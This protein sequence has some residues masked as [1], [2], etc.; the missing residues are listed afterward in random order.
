MQELSEGISLDTMDR[1][2]RRKLLYRQLCQERQRIRRELRHNPPQ[3]S[4]TFTGDANERHRDRDGEEHGAGL[5][6]RLSS[7]RGETPRGREHPPAEPHDGTRSHHRR[8]RRDAGEPMPE[9]DRQ[10]L[11]VSDRFYQ[12]TQD[13]PTSRCARLLPAA[14]PLSPTR[15][16]SISFSNYFRTPIGATAPD[17][18]PAVGRQP[19]PVPAPP[20][21]SAGLSSSQN[22][23]LPHHLSSTPETALNSARSRTSPS[24]TPALP[25]IPDG[26]GAVLGV[27]VR[28]PSDRPTAPPT[29]SQGP[30]RPRA[31][32]QGA[33]PAPVL[34]ATTVVPRQPAPGGAAPGG[35]GEVVRQYRVFGQSRIPVDDGTSSHSHSR[36]RSRTASMQR[37]SRGV[38]PPGAAGRPQFPFNP[39]GRASR[40]YGPTEEKESTPS[41]QQN[42]RSRTRSPQNR[43][44]SPQ[45]RQ[46]RGQRGSSPPRGPPSPVATERPPGDEGR[47]A[48][49]TFSPPL[50]ERPQQQQQQQQQPHTNAGSYILPTPRGAPPAQA[51]RRYRAGSSGSLTSLPYAVAEGT[52]ALV[53]GGAVMPP[54]STPLATGRSHSLLDLHR[55]SFSIA[56]GAEYLASPIPSGRSRWAGAGGLSGRRHGS[57]FSISVASCQSYGSLNNSSR[58][59][60]GHFHYAPAGSAGASAASFGTPL[61]SPL[62]TARRLRQRNCSASLSTAVI[63]SAVAPA[64]VVHQEPSRPSNTTNSASG[65]R[66]Q[67]QVGS[68]GSDSNNP[69]NASDKSP[70]V[71]HTP[72]SKRCVAQCGEP[73][74]SGGGDGGAKPSVGLTTPSARYAGHRTAAGP[75]PEEASNSNSNSLLLHVEHPQQVEL[76]A[77]SPVGR[78]ALQ[79]QR[80]DSANNNSSE[81]SAKMIVGGG[82]THAY[83]SGRGEGGAQAA[84]QRKPPKLM[85]EMM[86]HGQTPSANCSETSSPAAI[87]VPSLLRRQS[88][89]DTLRYAA[90]TQSFALKLSDEGDQGERHDGGVLQVQDGSPAVAALEEAGRRPRRRGGRA[91]ATRHRRDDANASSSSAASASPLKRESTE[92]DV[93]EGVKR[94]TENNNEKKEEEGRTSTPNPRRKPGRESASPPPGRRGKRKKKKDK[95]SEQMQAMKAF[96][97]I[98]GLPGAS[99]DANTN[100]IEQPCDSS[101]PAPSPPPFYFQLPVSNNEQYIA[102]LIIETE[103]SPTDAFS[104]HIP[105]GCWLLI[106]V[107]LTEEEKIMRRTDTHQY[108]ESTESY[109]YEVGPFTFVL[110]K[111]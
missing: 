35:T 51:T 101:L 90:R 73:P 14:E 55:A 48:N 1:N 31:A 2:V 91:S 110:E 94:T 108:R 34:T 11:L 45:Q 61:P 68:Q 64:V 100:A 44:Q 97:K 80:V 19:S 66:A 72:L 30:I 41:G 93:D 83:F 12:I 107:F 67:Q 39:R 49:P 21:G 63:D 111:R 81:L 74:A 26:A 79:Q 7:S 69:N 23:S 99:D 10:A 87:G 86:A 92:S 46:Q 15:Q 5:Q 27:V 105:Y 47:R 38:T 43:D 17:N 58:V 56:D 9:A 16:A 88:L 32:V 13:M 77:F 18:F 37:G 50:P 85:S 25:G 104:L 106:L 3:A 70:A 6:H 71:L 89:L 28:Q 96:A 22:T 20:G 62:S 75:S 59:Y 98:K 40:L 52:A 24:A 103:I 84:A 36:S 42:S 82:R 54:E 109:Y 29:Q 102:L 4:S 60:G 53:S 57:P 76:D 95:K 8:R 65:G 33:A 78:R